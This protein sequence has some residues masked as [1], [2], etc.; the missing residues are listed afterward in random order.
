MNTSHKNTNDHDSTQVK[1]IIGVIVAVMVVV[2][3]ATI[4][5]LNSVQVRG[6][7]DRSPQATL[8]TAA[9]AAYSV[10][11]DTLSGGFHNF[12]HQN[13]CPSGIIQDP[14]SSP[15]SD[16]TALAVAALNEEEPGINFVDKATYGLLKDNPPRP[17]DVWV[18]TIVESLNTT[19]AAARAYS[20]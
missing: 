6:P 17:H 15:T 9:A 3:L 16:A 14:C 11:A 8:R 5:T 1:T 20:S 2:I 19:P 4:I 18:D 7:L 12:S 10:Y 13:P